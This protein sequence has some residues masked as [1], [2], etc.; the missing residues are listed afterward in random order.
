MK[1][2]SAS[3]GLL[4]EALKEL[5][6]GFSDLPDIDS[7]CDV[8]TMREILIAVATRMRDNYPY[9]HPFY[10]GQMLK[11]PHPIARLAYA[12]SMWINP[13]N[14]AL[15]GGR[16]SSF[17]EKEA[18]AEIA[19][20]WNWQDFLGHLTGGGTI[21]LGDNQVNTATSS[22]NFGGSIAG[23]ANS[24]WVVGLAQS[25]A[26]GNTFGTSTFLFGDNSNFFG[27]FEIRRGIIQFSS[28]LAQ[29]HASQLILGD[30]AANNNI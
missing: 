1:L 10:A 28:Q 16:A 20:L 15:D 29:G 26:S 3:L 23:S 7:V 12:L 6:G 5:D 27:Q 21:N 30:T 19:G 11:P 2:E 18:V 22:T 14:H 17:M 25:E 4:Q 8:S 13:N 9:F 24:K